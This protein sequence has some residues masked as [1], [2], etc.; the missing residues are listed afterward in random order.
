DFAPGRRHVDHAVYYERRGLLPAPRIEV[1]VPGEAESFDRLGVDARQ[2]AETLLG[3]IAPVRHPLAGVLGRVGAEQA[4]RV[5][6]R[7]LRAARCG[8]RDVFITAAT[9]GERSEA[10][11]GDRSENLAH[12]E[13]PRVPICTC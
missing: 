4:S 6:R 10:A 2:R 12:T 9:G 11:D 3:V 7:I 5:D 1:R 13:A 8:G